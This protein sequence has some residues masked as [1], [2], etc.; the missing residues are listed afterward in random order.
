MSSTFFLESIMKTENAVNTMNEEILVADRTEIR[1]LT[2]EELNSVGGAG[3][4]TN[5]PPSL[6]VQ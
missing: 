6:S 4:A 1:E 2:A 5:P 3:H